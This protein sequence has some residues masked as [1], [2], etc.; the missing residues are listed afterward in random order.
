[1]AFPSSGPHTNGYSLVRQILRDYPE[2]CNDHYFMEKLCQPHRSYLPEIKMLKHYHPNVKI[3][4]L[5]H[6]TGGGLTENPKRVLPDDCTI[7][8]LEWDWPDVFKTLQRYGNVSTHE[9]LTV[10]NC[11][12]GMMVIVPDSDEAILKDLFHDIFKIGTVVE[13]TIVVEK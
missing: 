3:N 10:F 11:G 5:C 13:K 12:I 4:G 9:M 6:I 8:Y 2:L 1:M 7:E